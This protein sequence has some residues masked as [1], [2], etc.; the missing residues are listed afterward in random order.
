MIYFRE[1][2]FAVFRIDN[3]DV[4]FLGLFGNLFG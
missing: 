4:F 2:I 3:L 1:Q